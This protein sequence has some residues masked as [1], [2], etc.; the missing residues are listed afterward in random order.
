MSR[1]IR[2]EMCRIDVLSR[3]Q[4]EMFRKGVLSRNFRV[5]MCRIWQNGDM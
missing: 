3:V 4:V 5:E 2:V 1:D